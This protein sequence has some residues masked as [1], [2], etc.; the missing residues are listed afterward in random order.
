MM[1]FARLREAR[2]AAR[3]TR[4]E[5][6][7]SLQM[8]PKTL[9]RWEGGQL[10]PQANA[11]VTLAAFIEGRL[12]AHRTP[13]GISLQPTIHSLPPLVVA[14]IQQLVQNLQ[15]ALTAPLHNMPT[16]EPAHIDIP[17]LST[18]DSAAIVH[19]TM[20]SGNI[21][22]RNYRFPQQIDQRIDAAARAD[23]TVR[24]KNELVT[25]LLDENLPPLP[26]DYGLGTD[27]TD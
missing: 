15:H 5:L 12:A 16:G 22:Q 7:A 18:P 11:L 4:K 19:P 10:P 3:L 27:D 23:L 21:V 25:R 24:S 2:E 6:A 14:R 20:E 1:I 17:H 8:T 13:E 26:E 9:A